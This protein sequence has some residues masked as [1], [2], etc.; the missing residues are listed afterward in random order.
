[1]LANDSTK[2]KVDTKYYYSIVAEKI[3]ELTFFGVKIDVSS[4]EIIP[5]RNEINPELDDCEVSSLQYLYRNIEDYAIGHICSANWYYDN[6]GIIHVCSEFMP[7]VETPD[8]E[9]EPRDKTKHIF[10]EESCS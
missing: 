1:M 8:V 7:S 5:Y 2:V 10:D 9:P 4:S 3:N 6:N